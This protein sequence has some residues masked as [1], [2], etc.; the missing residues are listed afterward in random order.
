LPEK[1]AMSGVIRTVIESSWRVESIVHPKWGV[2]G[3]CT[4]TSKDAG[5]CRRP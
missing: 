3:V 5:K 2:L 4:T 1:L